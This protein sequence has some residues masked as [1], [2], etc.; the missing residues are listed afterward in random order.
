MTDSELPTLVEPG[1]LEPRLDEPDIRVLD[2]SVHL[3]VDAETGEASIA[4]AREDWEESHVPG[5]AYADLITDLSVT[6]DPDYPFQLPS[7]DRF[8]DAME[9][10]GVG[11]DSRVV[12]YDAVETERSNEWAARV[13]WMLRVFGHDEVGVL[14]GGFGRWTAEDRAVGSAPPEPRDATFTPAYREELVA[15]KHEVRERIGDGDTAL[16]DALPPTEHAS[17]HIPDSVNVP[18]VGE[19]AIIDPETGTYRS[20]EALRE[21]FHAVGAT[22]TEE[23]I[24]Y[25]GGGIAA[26]SAALALHRIGVEDVAVYDGSLS[27]WSD[28]PDLP[29]ESEERDE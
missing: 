3:T 5:S 19:D 6:D 1:W 2:C 18:A 13:W 25:C 16:V 26:S 27:E 10:L 11:E 15:G 14:N 8:A 23:V 12:V 17:G 21:R 28:D 29:M 22:E 20:R 24:T 7:P 9:R 4:P